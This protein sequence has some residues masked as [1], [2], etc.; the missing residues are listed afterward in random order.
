[1][2]LLHAQ[3]ALY[4][5]IG[6]RIMPFLMACYLMALFDRTNVGVAKLQ[7]VPDL[8][9]SEGEFGFG[10]GIFYLGYVLL[11]VPSNFM[12]NRIGLR[13][14]LLR[15]MMA[16]GAFTMAL[17][18]MWSATSYSAFRFLLGMAEAGFFPGII[19]YM[20]FWIPASR[21]AWFTGLLMSCP[22]IAGIISGLLAASI[23][24][25]T[26]G[27]Q[28]MHGWR[29]LFLIEGAPAI[30]LGVAGMFVLSDTPAQARWLT[31]AERAAVVADVAREREVPEEG[32][33]A[34]VR[35]TLGSP[36]FILLLC[37]CF[38]LFSSTSVSA[39]WAPSIFRNA[40]VTS[41]VEVGYL[42]MVPN[43]VA[44]LS[45]FAVARSSDRW[46]ERHLHSAGCVIVAAAGWLLLPAT[47][48]NVPMTLLALTMVTAGTISAFAPFF[49]LPAAY[50]SRQAA[51]TGIALTTS[52][53]S[54]AGF[55]VPLLVGRYVTA[56]DFSA[57]QYIVGG[58]MVMGAF[59]LVVLAVWF[60]R[61]ASVA[62]RT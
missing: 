13:R 11:E 39:F 51:P 40:G 58:F 49:S 3:A 19:L 48:H 21:R 43:L 61:H 5:K 32:H 31:P 55:A 42:L 62:A 45:Q 54:F 17:A 4:R 25:W 1:M 14:T 22:A 50:L 7:F 56:T 12:M 20:T 29:W 57:G 33:Q 8:H 35:E 47:S 38:T 53:G 41:V 44:L 52:V 9:L 30:L 59:T 37:A 60:R 26:D 18:F 24:H 46:Q 6:W 16:W 23:M 27:W 2:E 28:G 15:I 10:A 34:S 36:A